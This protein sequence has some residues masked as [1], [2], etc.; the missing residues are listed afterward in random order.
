MPSRTRYARYGPPDRYETP[1]PAGF[2]ISVFAILERGPKV[3]VGTP[4]EHPRWQGEWMPQL[5]M[6][7]KADR[8][9]VWHSPRLPSAYLREGENPGDA[10][11]RVVRGQLRARSFEATDVDV[12]SWTYPSDWY[13]GHDHWDLAFAFRVKARP[14][15]KPGPW[16]QEL[17]WQPK[18]LRSKDFGWND[19]FVRYLGIA[20]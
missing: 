7:S 12:S 14:P 19:D 5:R 8:E 6:Y 18:P 11:A 2:C 20:R 17:G 16:W 10:L 4:R 3:L 15:A 13:P 9:Q 1:P